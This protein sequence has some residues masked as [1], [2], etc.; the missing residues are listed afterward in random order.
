MSIVDNARRIASD[1]V[2][3]FASHHAK[4]G[5]DKL[6][7]RNEI[8]SGCSLLME[9]I[10]NLHGLSDQF[11]KACN[12]SC[13]A[14]ME[15]TREFVVFIRRGQGVDELRKVGNRAL[16]FANLGGVQVDVCL[17][18]DGHGYFPSS[19][20]AGRLPVIPATDSMIITV[21]Q[22]ARGVEKK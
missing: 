8:L 16:Q 10:G 11:V 22:L 2:A 19:F 6:P 5:P 9:G 12:R 17:A 18:F 1:G 20:R 3:S 15:W 14:V 4:R 13:V 21:G 7:G